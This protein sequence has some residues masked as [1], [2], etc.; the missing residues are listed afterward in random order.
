MPWILDV[1][2][3]MDTVKIVDLDLCQ[4]RLM[5]D[6]RFPWIILIPKRDGIEEVYQLNKNDQISLIKE[7]D[8]TSHV[9]RETFN[10]YKLNIAALGNMV[11]QLHIH[12]IARFESDSVWP[13]PVF[14]HGEAIP[15]DKD[16]LAQKIGK[17]QICFKEHRG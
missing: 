3:Q 8:V 15:Y 4:A 17:L 14:G 11:R 7:I 9:L 16:K 1:Q 6:Q 5:N 12:V 2:L 13:K 10:P